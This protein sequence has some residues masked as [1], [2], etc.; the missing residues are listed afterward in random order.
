MH[1]LHPRE[2]SLAVIAVAQKPLFKSHVGLA[3]VCRSLSWRAGQFRVGKKLYSINTPLTTSNF[4][5]R[6]SP[7]SQ[8]IPINT[9]DV[10]VIYFQSTFNFPR[11]TSNQFTLDVKAGY[12]FVRLNV[13]DRHSRPESFGFQ[14]IPL[15]LFTCDVNR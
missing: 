12:R 9:V 13:S 15:Q 6:A 8:K 11:W 7:A 5:I 3:K 1:H 2:T 10:Y 4:K 14:M